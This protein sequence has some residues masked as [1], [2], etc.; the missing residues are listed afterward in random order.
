MLHKSFAEDVFET[1]EAFFETSVASDE[2][3]EGQR[4]RSGLWNIYSTSC[5]ELFLNNHV[6]KASC[7][8][9]LIGISWNFFNCCIYFK[10]L[11]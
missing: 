11:P 5:F 1:V 8:V 7:N 4:R 3:S 2:P 9:K 10:L 6:E